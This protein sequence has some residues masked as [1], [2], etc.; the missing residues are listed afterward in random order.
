M[1]RDANSKNTGRVKVAVPR[2]DVK[3]DPNLF[4]SVGGRNYLLPRGRTSEVPP[5][6]AE[7]YY[8][9]ERAKEAFFARSDELLKKAK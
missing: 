8:R 1:A 9:S 5:E 6:V 3:G 4:I 2:G 7:E